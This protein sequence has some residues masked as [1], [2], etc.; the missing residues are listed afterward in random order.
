VLFLAADDLINKLRVKL[1]RV[2]NG[3]LWLRTPSLFQN[4]GGIFLFQQPLILANL[5]GETMILKE[6]VDFIFNFLIHFI[7]FIVALGDLLF[8]FVTVLHD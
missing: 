1:V 7:L 5:L 6:L 2:I 3:C 8:H 4:L